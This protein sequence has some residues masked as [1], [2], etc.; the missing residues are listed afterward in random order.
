MEQLNTILRAF[1]VLATVAVKLSVG[2]FFSRASSAHIWRRRLIWFMMSITVLFSIAYL[3]L[4]VYGCDIS[5]S[6]SHMNAVDTVVITW[7]TFNA[8]TNSAFSIIA[9]PGLVKANLR[10]TI[11]CLCSLLVAISC[12]ADAASAIRIVYVSRLGTTH[13]DV[14]KHDVAEIRMTYWDAIGVGVSHGLACHVQRLIST[15]GYHSCVMHNA[16][17][18]DQ[19]ENR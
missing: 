3:I 13:D 19:I 8:V 1:Y 15:V 11:M 18:I 7:S 12:I 17:T 10:T 5:R 6:C 2:I 14:R 4:V 16:T 9:I